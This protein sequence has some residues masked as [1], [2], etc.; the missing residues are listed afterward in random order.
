MSCRIWRFTNILRCLILRYI[1]EK[2]WREFR[3]IFFYHLCGVANVKAS[4]TKSILR[5]WEQQKA[6]SFSD[7]EIFYKTR[8]KNVLQIVSPQLNQCE[9]FFCVIPCGVLGFR[10]ISSLFFQT[11]KKYTG[12]IIRLLIDKTEFTLLWV[13][14]CTHQHYYLSI[15]SYKSMIKVQILKYCFVDLYINWLY[16]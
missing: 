15:L 13:Y 11:N 7:D 10:K 8:V 1:S 4:K 9:F 6:Y 14:K 2:C 5:Y 3:V 12:K 16:F